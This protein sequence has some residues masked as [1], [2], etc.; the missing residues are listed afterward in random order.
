MSPRLPPGTCV[1]DAAARVRWC[2]SRGRGA[3][4]GPD[5]CPC[6]SRPH[7][8]TQ[9]PRRDVRGGACAELP[10]Q[11]CSPAAPPARR[12]PWQ[13][14]R[15]AGLG[16]GLVQPFS[17]SLSDTLGLW[18][19]SRRR[20]SGPPSEQPQGS[21]PGREGGRGHSSLVKTPTNSRFIFDFSQLQLGN[22]NMNSRVF[23]SSKRG[24]GLK[25]IY[26]VVEMKS[27]LN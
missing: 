20:G 19:L 14:L 8:T 22:R 6:G 3:L 15:P 1:P 10:A 12:H 17:S 13:G 4:G 9:R 2:W 21:R 11:G 27:F 18:P 23:C 26:Y 5:R 16:T 25:K 7:P 24:H